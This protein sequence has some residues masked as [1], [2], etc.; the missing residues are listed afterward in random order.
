MRKFTRARGGD[1]LRSIAIKKYQMVVKTVMRLLL[2]PLAAPIVRVKAAGENEPATGRAKG[3]HFSEVSGGGTLSAAAASGAAAA[4]SGLC[5]HAP[6][7]AEA[8]CKV[9]A[10]G[11]CATAS[12][13]ATSDFVQASIA[14]PLAQ[15]QIGLHTTNELSDR[16][17]WSYVAVVDG[18]GIYCGQGPGWKVGPCG[19]AAKDDILRMHR[20]GDT[21]VT[22][23]CL[24]AQVATERCK[25]VTEHCPAACKT[26]HTETGAKG[27]PALYAHVGIH[28]R[29]TPVELCQIEP[30][31]EASWGW[32]FVLALGLGGGLYLGG[33]VVAGW[34]LMGGGGEGS[35]GRQ[36]PR[37]LS[38]HPHHRAMLELA[39]LVKDGLVF[40]RQRLRGGGGGGGGESGSGGRGSGKGK[41]AGGSLLQE[42]QSLSPSA[43]R[44]KKEKK[45][46]TPIGSHADAGGGGSGSGGGGNERPGAAAATDSTAAAA[47]GTAAGG[48]GRWVHVPT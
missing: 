7:L 33:G 25:A 30:V 15:T 22:E 11:Q 39:A 21:V 12:F 14:T 10:N 32:A 40:S 4:P 17:L 35:G 8:P 2:L 3:W 31:V 13:G 23:L 45:A 27:K 16:E 37:G 19:S 42:E 41:D 34:K 38:D 24:A 44:K 43:T 48:G 28:N 36:R 47:V 29:D 5:L 9:H 26:I 18:G 6:T 20:T 46:T 1:A